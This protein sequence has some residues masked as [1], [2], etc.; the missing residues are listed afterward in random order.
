MDQEDE[1]R[2]MASG[3]V[4]VSIELMTETG[5]EGEVDTHEVKGH[6]EPDQNQ[7]M[8][9]RAQPL[10]SLGNTDEG[11]PK[12]MSSA[13]SA[14]TIQNDFETPLQTKTRDEVQ[15]E[16]FEEVKKNLMANGTFEEKKEDDSYETPISKA[17]PEQVPQVGTYTW[18]CGCGTVSRA[19]AKFC[20]NCGK[21]KPKI[22]YCKKCGAGLVKGSK[23]CSPCGEPTGCTS[24]I[25]EEAKAEDQKSVEEPTEAVQ[26]VMSI[27]TSMATSSSPVVLR[28]TP[29]TTSI[30]RSPS[31]KGYTRSA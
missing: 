25:D 6:A 4:P 29:P 8:S 10:E 23:F 1:D 3:S 11:L 16:E 21:P 12:D 30:P 7:V 31:G 15:E 26:E 24:P 2:S 22:N 20:I 17:N 18:T 5:V 14:Q 27:T 19:H 13:Q 28:P 9:P